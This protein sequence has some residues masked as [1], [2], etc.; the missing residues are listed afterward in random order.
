VLCLFIVVLRPVRRC[1]VDTVGFRKERK[2]INA[3]LRTTMLGRPHIGA[4]GV[5]RAP[6]LENG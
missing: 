4:N 1:S 2:K 6:P 3:H 5:S